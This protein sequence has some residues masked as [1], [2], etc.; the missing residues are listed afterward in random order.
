MLLAELDMRNIADHSLI[1]DCDGVLQ[2]R[3]YFNRTARCT[4][5]KTRS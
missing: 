2:H 1:L 5:D 3:R 4:G